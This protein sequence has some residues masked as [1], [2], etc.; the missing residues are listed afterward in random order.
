MNF[1]FLKYFIE[2]F[3]YWLSYLGYFNLLT[4]EGGFTLLTDDNGFI[5]VTNDNGF[6]LVNVDDGEKGTFTLDAADKA[7]LRAIPIPLQLTTA[8]NP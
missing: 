2:L 4:D 3:K 5:L 1:E 7:G 6:I 8:S